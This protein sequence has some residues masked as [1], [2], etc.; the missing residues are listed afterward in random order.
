MHRYVDAEWELCARLGHTWA[1]RRA[2][3]ITRSNPAVA[4]ECHDVLQVADQLVV[5]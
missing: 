4:G 2:T 1:P 5:P 3:T